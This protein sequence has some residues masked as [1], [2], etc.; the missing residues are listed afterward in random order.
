MQNNLKKIEDNEE[1][2][3]GQSLISLLKSTFQQI[4]NKELPLDHLVFLYVAV[5]GVLLAVF[6]LGYNMIEGIGK[7]TLPVLLS[8][9]AVN[10]SSVLYSVVKK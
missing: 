7:H 10:I 3:S 8:Y 1:S 4:C 5:A 2:S 9:L 6:G